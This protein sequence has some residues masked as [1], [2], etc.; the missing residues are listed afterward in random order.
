MWKS[1]GVMTVGVLAVGC[2]GDSASPTAPMVIPVFETQAASAQANGGNFG[3]PLSGENEVPAN[4]SQG[5]GSAI[6]HLN[7]DG[8]ALDYELMVANIENVIMAHIH[9]APIGVNGGVVVWLF[10][11]TAV[12]PGA[13]NL[14]RFQGRIAEGTITDANLVGGLAGL[15]ISDLAAA[16]NAGNTYVNVHTDDGDATRNTGL[17][18]LFDGEIRGQLEHRGH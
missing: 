9:M 6:F 18:D 11:S 13:P 8:T 14:G 7:A 2:T 15:D 4:S 17:G 10:P 12:G 5:R 16:I 1:A 3:T